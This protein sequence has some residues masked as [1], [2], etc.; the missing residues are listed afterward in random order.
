MPNGH[1]LLRA[2]LAVSC[3]LAVADMFAQQG[4]T[5]FGIQVKPVFPLPYFD[6]SIT[7]ERQPLRGTIDL[8]GGYAFGMSVRI[9]LTR[10][11]SLETGLG[12]IQRRY[13]F[14]LTNEEVDYSGASEFRYIGYE[15][16]VTALVYIRLGERSY[17]NAALGFSADFY[18]GDVQRDLDDGRIYVFRNSWV[19]SGVLGNMGVEYRTERSGIIYMGATFHRP[20]NSMATVDLTYYDRS[21]NFF[22]TTLRAGL[23]G[24][25]LTVDLRYYFHEDPARR[26]RP[27]S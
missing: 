17:M 7:L 4:V 23:N 3:V 27:R 15:L 11:I 26:A 2:T 18:P 16:P 6:R 9:G 14:S 25:Y 21:N 5:T 8:E 24:S 22:P 20:F 1:L 13:A 19:Q 12:Q 10:T